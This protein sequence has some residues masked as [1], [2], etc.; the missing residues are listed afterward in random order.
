MGITSPYLS[1]I[2][3]N[4]PPAAGEENHKILFSIGNWLPGLWTMAGVL[5]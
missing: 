2:N 5:C 4:Q 3:K 1:L